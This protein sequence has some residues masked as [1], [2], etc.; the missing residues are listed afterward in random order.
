[1]SAKHVLIVD[2]FPV[3]RKIIVNNLQQISSCKI[4]EASDGEE[5][6]AKLQSETF[7]LLITDW[8]MP[9]LSGLDLVKKLKADP[10]LAKLPILMVTAESKK[11]QIV[12]AAKAGVN[13]YILK[14]FTPET[15]KEKLTKMKFE[16]N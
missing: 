11:E 9:K 1:M 7:D 8:N 6:L 2:D 16:F 12:V 3:M 5:A 13:G 15:L 14:P 10:K 4:S